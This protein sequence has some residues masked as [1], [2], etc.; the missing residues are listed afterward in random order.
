MAMTNVQLDVLRRRRAAAVSA[1]RYFTDNKSIKSPNNPFAFVSEKKGDVLYDYRDV[2]NEEDNN[3][4]V[5]AFE[6]ASLYRL[7][8]CDEKARILYMS[9]RG[10]P[11]LTT[12]DGSASTVSLVASDGYDHVFVIV[13]DDPVPAR[14]TTTLKSMP[15]TTMIVDG[16]TE[17]WYFP[18]LSWT[19][20]R[21]FGLSNVPNPRQLYVRTQ[22]E[23][24]PFALHGVRLMGPSGVVRHDIPPRPKTP[25]PLHPPR[26]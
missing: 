20:A 25:A 8:N 11:R 3:T 26:R 4:I 23:R 7:G 21:R 15:E 1:L 17:D 12:G 16:W 18:R 9:L 22:I 19:A 24:H 2:N 6:D 10:N 13:A 14:P 5:Q